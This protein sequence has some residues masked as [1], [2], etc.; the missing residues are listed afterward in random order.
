MQ[1][2]TNLLIL[3]LRRALKFLQ[4]DFLELELLQSSGRANEG[5]AKN[6]Y[7]RL[8]SRLQEELEKN[9]KNIYFSDM[10]F[11]EYALQNHGLDECIFV[12][13]IDSLSN[14]AKSLPFFGLSLTYL[15]RLNNSTKTL[16]LPEKSTLGILNHARNPDDDHLMLQQSEIAFRNWTSELTS[17]TTIVILPAFDSLYYAE[18]GYGVSCEQNSNS[19]TNKNTRLRT[20]SC[21]D[22]NNALIATNDLSKI[23]LLPNNIRNFGSRI[24]ELIL[25][26]S[27]KIDMV[28]FHS[29]DYSLKCAF[30]LIV[31]ESGGIIL[32]DDR[33]FIATNQSLARYAE[34]NFVNN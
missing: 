2:I 31:K 6:S 9:V 24:Y 29:L 27:G 21:D 22:I 7:V 26:A 18:R 28:S 13:P 5:F 11:S 12:N 34:E 3:S 33:D 1:P 32:R 15:K 8:K 20:S 19:L 4:R 17:L 30:E 16:A 14:L 25:F 23:N 10:S